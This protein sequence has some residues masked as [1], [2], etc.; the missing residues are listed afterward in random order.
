[1]SKFVKITLIVVGI[2]FVIGCF[3]GNSNV[4]TSFCSALNSI[5]DTASGVCH[6]VAG[7]V[8]WVVKGVGSLI[9]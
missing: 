9:G 3:V 7:G 8:S 2:F 5:V 1:M 6:N 4:G